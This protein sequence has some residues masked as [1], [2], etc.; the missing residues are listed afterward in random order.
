MDTMLV[1]IN[2]S[3]GAYNAALYALGLAQQLKISRLILYNSYYFTPIATE[4]P[5]V[6]YVDLQAESMNHLKEVKSKLL[7]FIEKG[8]II[9]QLEADEQALS[10]AV[11]SLSAEFNVGIVVMGAPAKTNLEETLSGSNTRLIAKKFKGPLL[12]VPEMANYQKIERVIL[13]TDLKKVSESIPARVIKNLIHSLNAKLCVLNVDHEEWTHFH[14]DAMLEQESLH[15][16]WDEES[17]D[18]YYI[19]H[20]D[21][22]EGIIRFAEENHAQLIISIPKKHGFLDGLFH[23]SITKKLAHH[24]PIPLLLIHN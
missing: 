6:E 1:L 21:I 17:C 9:I 20:K 19:D 15:K 22:V 4:V 2:F 12:I 14:P 5:V 23:Q 8:E 13:A 24:S 18:Y 16:M 7:Q 10:N 3:T 11:V